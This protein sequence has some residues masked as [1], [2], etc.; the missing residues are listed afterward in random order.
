MICIGL[1]I[2]LPI[3]IGLRGPQTQNDQNPGVVLSRDIG[4]DFQGWKKTAFTSINTVL[5]EYGSTPNETWSSWLN[6]N[7]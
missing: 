3:V 2:A 1:K 4:T 5:E 7:V 6:K